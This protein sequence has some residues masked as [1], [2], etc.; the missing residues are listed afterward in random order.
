LA[1]AYFF[2]LSLKYIPVGVAYACWTGIAVVGTVLAGII[3]FKEPYK[4]FRMMF[5]LFIIVGI[6]GLKVTSPD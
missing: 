1:C 5:I 4:I 2:S 3:I 6:I